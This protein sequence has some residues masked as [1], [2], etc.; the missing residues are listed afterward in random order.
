METL[1]GKKIQAKV[2]DEN[3]QFYFAQAEDGLTYRID[4]SEIKKPLKKDSNFS[5]FAYE[6]ANHERQMTREAPKATTGKYGWGR[7][8]RFAKT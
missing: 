8:L 1:L 4:K 3:D 7:W 5:G 2:I 6:N